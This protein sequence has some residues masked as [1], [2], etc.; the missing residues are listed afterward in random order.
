MTDYRPSFHHLALLARERDAFMASL[1]AIY[2]EQEE[3]DEAELAWFLET[4]V[5]ALMRLALCRRPRMDASHFDRDIEQIASYTNVNAAQL[6]RLARAAT[7]HEAGTMRTTK[8]R[9]D[10]HYSESDLQALFALARHEDV[11]E[12][13]RYD[14]RSAA[15]NVWTH[16]WTHAETLEES[17]TMGTFYFRWTEPNKLWQIECDEAFS[18]D[19]LFLELGALEEKALGRKIHGR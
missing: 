4:D 15:I 9:V 17:E 3:L 1:L 8:H 11:E 5:Q 19:D 16:K 2:Q 10:L 18:P 6:A 7:T 14:A 13:G 12:G